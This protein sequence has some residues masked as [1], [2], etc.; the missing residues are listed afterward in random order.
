MN[1]LITITIPIWAL[2][3][4]CG[5]LL[6]G[7]ILDVIKVRLKKRIAD[8]KYDRFLKKFKQ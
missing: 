4:L 2:F 7:A 3:I 8:K 1:E 5:F 6:A